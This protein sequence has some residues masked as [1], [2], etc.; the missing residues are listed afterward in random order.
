MIERCSTF[1]LGD[2][3]QVYDEITSEDYHRDYATNGQIKHRDKDTYTIKDYGEVD[4]RT[5]QQRKPIPS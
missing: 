5:P 3:K 1:E 4:I 2:S